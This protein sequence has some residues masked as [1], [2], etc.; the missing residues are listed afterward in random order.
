MYWWNIQRGTVSPAHGR[1]FIPRVERFIQK[2]PRVY[3]QKP[4]LPLVE[5]RHPTSQVT[6]KNGGILGVGGVIL[7]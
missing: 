4:K 7:D 1:K 6:S 2:D 3:T 5:K